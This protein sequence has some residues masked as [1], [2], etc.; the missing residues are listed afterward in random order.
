MD[1]LKEAIPFFIDLK[2]GTE[3][4]VEFVENPQSIVDEKAYSANDE[5]EIALRA[6]RANLKDRALQFYQN[7]A[8]EARSSWKELEG[9]FIQGYQLTP[10]QTTDPNKYFNLV[11]TLR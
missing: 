8:T 4:P 5:S 10:K 3:E 9:A 6:L 1:V 11:Y 2:D 7:P